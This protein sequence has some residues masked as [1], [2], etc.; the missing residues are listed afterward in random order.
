MNT[1]LWCLT[2]EMIVQATNT[3]SQSRLCRP[4]YCIL[5]NPPLITNR[6]IPVAWKQALKQGSA[7][8]QECSTELKLLKPPDEGV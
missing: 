8:F 5:F 1:W 2:Q 3:S 6:R 7:T 4:L